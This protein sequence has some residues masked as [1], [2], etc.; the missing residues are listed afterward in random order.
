MPGWTKRVCSVR[1]VLVVDDLHWADQSTLDVLMFLLA[2][3][4]DR[5]L[6]VV[7]TVRTGEVREGHPL[8]RWRADVRRLPRV[9]EISLGRL[10]RAATADQVAGL[11]GRPP[12]QA[13][14]DAVFART[15]GNAYLTRLIV[16]N[17]PPDARIV[18]A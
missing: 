11:L 17:I 7:A 10:D 2:G 1:V 14:V 16:R 15:R 9:D 18:A 4:A 6:G 13:L 8:R 5:R 12:H 3:R